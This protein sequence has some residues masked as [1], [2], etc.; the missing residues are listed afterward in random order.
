[1]NAI[2]IG[3]G[4]MGRRRIRLLRMLDPGIEICGVDTQEERRSR[5]EREFG[6][7][8]CET[9]DDA[10]E[11][12]GNIMVAFVSSSPLSHSTIIEKCLCKGSHV[13]SEINLVD[14][15]YEKNVEIAKDKKLTLF[16]SST[17][18]YRREIEYIKRSVRDSDHFKSYIFHVGQYLP[19]WHPWESYKDFFV[20]DKR[21]NACRE[22]MAIEFPW[23]FD[24]FGL[25]E[26]WEVRSNKHSSLSVDYPDLFQII[27]SHA[28][29][30]TGMVQIDLISRKAIRN[31][32]CVAE[33][34]YISWDGTPDGLYRYDYIDKK[35]DSIKLYDAVDKRTDY[36]LSIIEDPYMAEIK[37]FLDT[38]NNN[39]YP[40][41]S[42]TRDINVL[43]VIDSIEAIER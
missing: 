18:M 38:I 16:L 42:F 9:I 4:S 34:M 5:A 3:L 32:E 14:T 21:T 23:L 43:H 8:T 15:G 19:D 39:T 35:D 17:P 25:P 7:K 28:G 36:S 33:D 37:E 12:N 30:N 20:G 11:V 22:I 31:F 6:I 27:F 1:M 26:K 13:F 2:V 10:Y 41:Y 40:R 29:G 24:T